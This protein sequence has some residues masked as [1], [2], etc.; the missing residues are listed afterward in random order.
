M[1]A[2]SARR[3]TI[4]TAIH[5]LRIYRAFQFG[6]NIDMI[7]TDNRSYMSPPVSDSTVPSFDFGANTQEVN[8]ILDQGRDYAGGSPPATIRVGANKVANPQRDAPPQP[9]SASNKWLGSRRVCAQR[10]RLGKSGAIPLARSPSARIRKICH[11][12][13]LPLGQAPSMATLNAATRLSMPKYSEWC[14][15]KASPVSPSSPAT[16][17]PSGQAILAR[18]CRR[19]RSNLWASSSSAAQ[20]RQA[21]LAEVQERTLPHD[22]PLRPFYVHDRPDGS[23]QCAFNTTILH[24]VRAALALRDTDDPARATRMSRRTSPSRTG[25]D[26]AIPRCAL[27]RANWK[28]SSCAFRARWNAP[29]NEDGGPLRYRAVHRVALWA[30]GERPA[31][32]ARGSRRRRRSFN[33]NQTAATRDAPLCASSFA[34]SVS[35]I[36]G[37]A[38]W[39]MAGLTFAIGFLKRYMPPAGH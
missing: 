11:P 14:A 13:S 27:L 6:K 5:A 25:A 17:T 7:L 29:G 26:T 33:L 20:S 32:A 8:D 36:A 18:I 10:T 9:T 4:F 37:G 28:P 23:L 39:L 1:R 2:A 35:A 24:G 31:D 34:L 16:N 22:N 19:T 3:T 15:L 38:P 30:P 21:G 12:S